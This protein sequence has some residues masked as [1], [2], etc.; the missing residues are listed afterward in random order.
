MAGK[1]L[2]SN[3]FKQLVL[4]LLK[5]DTESIGGSLLQSLHARTSACMH[6]A[7]EESHAMQ[8]KMQGRHHDTHF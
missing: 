6:D 5:Y 7:A 4:L 2:V 8:H 1:R 3:Q